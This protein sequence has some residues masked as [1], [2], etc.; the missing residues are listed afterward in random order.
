M[1]TSELF[2]LECANDTRQFFS[3]CSLCRK[4]KPQLRMDSQP[5]ENVTIEKNGRTEKNRECYL[6]YL[7]CLRKYKYYGFNSCPCSMKYELFP[8]DKLH[9]QKE[10]IML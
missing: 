8:L 5:Q 3:N 6:L 4:T 2:T 10:V 7:D 9:I 1:L